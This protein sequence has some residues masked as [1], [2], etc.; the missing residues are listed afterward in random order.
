MWGYGQRSGAGASGIVI[1][2]IPKSSSGIAQTTN[3]NY[4]ASVNTSDLDIQLAS[5]GIINN[6]SLIILILIIG[7]I[8]F[9]KL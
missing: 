5:L 6:I 1:I 2:R 7:F 8:G 9:I 3:S 4:L